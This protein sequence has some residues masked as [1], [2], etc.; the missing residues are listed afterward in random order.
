ML[1]M[2]RY[3]HLNQ[4]I[5]LIEGMAVNIMTHHLYTRGK[6]A[7]NR[8]LAA[9][10]CLAWCL[11]ASV[12]VAIAATTNQFQSHDSI[13]QTA[14][15]YVLRL[16]DANEQVEITTNKLDPRLKLAICTQALE[17]FMS[18]GSKTL[19]RTTVGVRCNGNV[20]WSMHIPVNVKLF[21]SVLVTRQA[22]ARGHLIGK[23][24]IHLVK[25]DVS[26]MHQPYV[27]DNKLA[28]GMIIKR[29]LASGAVINAGMLQAPILVRRGQN[30]TLL[31]NTGGI[32][33]RMQGKS[34]AN[35]AAGER[36]RVRN[37]ASR[38]IVEGEVTDNGEIRV[39]M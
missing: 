24:D 15:D 29:Q 26:T 16:R 3:F 7:A 5:K 28:I 17:A 31:A 25:R 19:G 20:P 12:P 32:Q 1:T 22:L 23:R 34:M 30:V 27:T 6:A 4:L 18:P 9:G 2:S 35:G 37:T 8:L 21:K 11:M 10:P 38:R 33:V 13:R 14:R 39:D 36:V